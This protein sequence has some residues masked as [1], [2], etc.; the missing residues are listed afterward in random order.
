MKGAL[1]LELVRN[2]FPPE[3]EFRLK[4]LGWASV[5]LRGMKRM[6][7]EG[8]R[9]YVSLGGQRK[10]W[11]EGYVGS[12]EQAIIAGSK[13]ARALESMLRTLDHPKSVGTFIGEW[14]E[15]T[16]IIAVI[17]WRTGRKRWVWRLGVKFGGGFS[18]PEAR[19]C[20]LDQSNGNGN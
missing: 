1:N 17:Q 7:H 20:Y 13:P 2:G 15:P 4:S 11:R 6:T 19:G 14:D 16:G 18:N 3:F 5:F 10:G 12:E 8:K 9:D